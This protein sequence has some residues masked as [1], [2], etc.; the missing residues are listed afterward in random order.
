V[1]DPGYEYLKSTSNHNTVLVDGRGQTGEGNTWLNVNNCLNREKEPLGI[2]T[3]EDR[4]DVCHVIADVTGA[5]DPDLRITRFTRRIVYLRPDLIVLH[6]RIESA[7]PHEYRWLLH[8][9]PSDRFT[10]MRPGYWRMEAAGAGLDICVLAPGAEALCHE[11][12]YHR[13]SRSRFVGQTRRMDLHTNH[14]EAR[15]EFLVVLKILRG[16]NLARLPMLD[17]SVEQNAGE[18]RLLGPNLRLSWNEN[19]E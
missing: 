1:T 9:D 16:E 15:Q 13:I 4:G 10:E 6:D 11:V 2:T 8:T 7:M 19:S 3:F 14:P 18:I 12:R 5:Y 17:L